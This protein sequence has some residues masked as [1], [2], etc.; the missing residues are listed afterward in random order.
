VY[1]ALST[2]VLGSLPASGA[3][4]LALVLFGKRAETASQAP[5]LSEVPKGA[6]FR[7]VSD[8]E[9]RMVERLLNSRSR[10]RLGW[11]APYEVFY[12]LTGVALES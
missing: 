6:E 11:N 12:D 4:R 9:I 8:E 1:A 7:T 2:R 3:F 10:K 5:G